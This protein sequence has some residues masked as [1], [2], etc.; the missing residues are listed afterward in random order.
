LAPVVALEALVARWV[1]GCPWRAAWKVSFIANLVTTVVGLPI[2]WALMFLL[3]L[4]AST[5]T[6]GLD[7]DSAWHLVAAVFM[8]AWLSPALEGALWW[9]PLAG[10]V[11]SVPL[12][13][14]SVWI[15][16]G[17]GRALLDLPDL[18]VVHRWSWWANGW[19]Y[20]GMEL[21]W[22]GSALILYFDR[23]AG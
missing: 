21:V 23:T 8:F 18:R 3:E 1:I 14:A 11:L 5:A 16:V 2:V 15:E 19:T 13:F 6:A 7:P 9:I 12:F 22:L 10:A 4:W 20:L 17:V